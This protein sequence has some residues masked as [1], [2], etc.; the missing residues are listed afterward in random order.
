MFQK[1]TPERFFLFSQ[2]KKRK[3]EEHQRRAVL[4]FKAIKRIK[5]MNL[6]DYLKNLIVQLRVCFK[7]ILPLLNG[8][9]FKRTTK[10]LGLFMPFLGCVLFMI[11][12]LF[13]PEQLKYVSFLTVLLTII[14]LFWCCFDKNALG[15]LSYIF[16]CGLK[17]FLV[18]FLFSLCVTLEIFVCA[19]YFVTRLMWLTCVFLY[20]FWLCLAIIHSNIAFLSLSKALLTLVVVYYRLRVSFFN[21]SILD[22]PVNQIITLK[23]SFCLLDKSVILHGNLNPLLSSSFCSKL[24]KHTNHL[25]VPFLIQTRGMATKA[26]AETMTKGLSEV[27]IQNPGPFIT[28]TGAIL[29][30]VIA[31][32]VA[33]SYDSTQKQ[34]DR[35][36]NEAI[37][38]RQIDANAEIMNRKSLET[39]ERAQDDFNNKS[40][41]FFRVRD[42]D[43]ET[44]LKTRVDY[45]K[46]KGEKPSM[47]AP[48][49]KEIEISQLNR[50]GL[51]ETA[52]V[53][54]ASGLK[55]PLGSGFIPSPLDLPEYPIV[56]VR[57]LKS[58]CKMFIFF[59]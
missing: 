13:T 24:S 51:A 38:K 40:R 5:K 20:S 55:G 26:A 49:Y 41:W 29:A 21:A 45:Y 18:Q 36:S 2:S 53:N 52:S 3:Q 31:T 9:K 58:I 39:A 8:D 14:L 7:S 11:R 30:G 16:R 57:L 48:L 32:V 54:A 17:N 34:K 25:S 23:E 56:T 27:V 35:D 15:A 10:L 42:K 59:S 1:R 33:G 37:A 19:P 12:P 43:Q 46:V 47:S 6:Y 22:L 50:S 44:I 4:S 28:A